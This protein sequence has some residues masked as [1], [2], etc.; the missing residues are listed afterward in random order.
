MEPPMNRK[1][2]KPLDVVKVLIRLQNFDED[3]GDV[4]TNLKAQK[5]VY[6]AQGMSYALL[7]DQLFEEDFEAWLHGPVIPS[8]YESLKQFGNSQLEIDTE[9]DDRL[10]SDQQLDIIV[11]TY[12]TF[13][14]YS[15]WKL[16]D[17]THQ[18]APWKN[19]KRNEIISKELIK[20]YFTQ[21]YSHT[22]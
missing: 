20:S 12:K 18:E 5:L 4:I 22:I 14:Q 17:M 6:Y 9:Y 21:Q 8:L 2:I 10:F 15:A 16:R 19:T 3:C 1:T 11:R 7:G 13:G